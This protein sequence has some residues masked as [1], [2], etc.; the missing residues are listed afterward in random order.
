MP[1]VL[2]VRGFPVFEDFAVDR[3]TIKATRIQFALDQAPSDAPSPR[4]PGERLLFLEDPPELSHE[5]RIGLDRPVTAPFRPPSR[6]ATA[7][8]VR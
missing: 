7:E 2:R 8:V 5:Q 3:H 1:G 6:A 4:F